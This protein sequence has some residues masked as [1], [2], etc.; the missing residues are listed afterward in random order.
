[1]GR[2][3]I[4]GGPHEIN[5]NK[6]SKKKKYIKVNTI[7]IHYNKKKMKIELMINS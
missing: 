7:K 5:I 4:S 1:M 6:V 2:R 3:T